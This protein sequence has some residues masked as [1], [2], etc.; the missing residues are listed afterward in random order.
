MT[1][2]KDLTKGNLN[3]QIFFFAMP[4]VISNLFQAL[5]NA[6]DMYFVGKYIGMAGTVAV[7]VGGPVMNVLFMA[8][9]GISMGVTIILGSLVGTKDDV[10][11]KKTANTAITMF[12]CGAVFITLMGMSA[13]PLILKIMYTPYE[14]YDMAVEYLRI[15]FAGMIFTLGYNLVC[16]IQRGFGDSKSSMYFVLAAAITNIVL[17]YIFISKF[18]MGVNGAALATVISQALSFVLS[19]IYFRSKKH[20]VDFNPKDFCFDG[21]I[22]SDIIKI[23]LPSAFQQAA[24]NIACIALNGIVNSFGIF[25]SA[26]YGIC[27]KLDSFAVLPCSAVNDAVAA[28]TSQNL[29]VDQKER[30]INSISAGRR[31]IIPFNLMLMVV[32]FFFGEKFASIFNS[33]P[34]VIS[35]AHNYIRISCFM[36]FFY[37]VYYPLMGFVKGTGNAMFTLKNTVMAQFVIRIPVAYICSK[38]LGFGFYGVAIAWIVAPI[39]SNTIYTIYLK[40]GKWYERLK[41]N[42]KMGHSI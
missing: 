18:N 36:Y 19:V 21:A 16:A 26:A 24:I 14:A 8:V 34:V 4:I 32:M 3:W 35:M 11:I 29:G 39:Y 6:V 30:A 28:I 15:I 25:A 38:V 20:I 40:S 42:Q 22:A 2:K 37:A 5:Y 31:L 27:S 9:A 12:L 13:S 1:L 23:G 17:D 7:S 41:N 10:K 33:D